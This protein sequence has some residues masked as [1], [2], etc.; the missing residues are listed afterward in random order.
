M[1]GLFP[2]LTAL[3]CINA[4]FVLMEFAL[5]RVRASRIEML[6]RKGNPRALQV[7]DVL[8]HLDVYLAAIQVGL[9]IVALT[10]GWIGEPALAERLGH[11]LG[12]LPVEAHPHLVHVLAYVLALLALAFFQTVF[13]ELLPRFVGIQKAELV[14]LWG[15]GALRLFALVF[16][17]PISFMSYCSST[18]LKLFG[19]K[20][21]GESESIVSEEEMRILLGE[22]Q[23]RGS[24]PLERLLLLENLFDLGAAKAAEAMV[25]LEKVAYLSLKRSWEEN[26]ET[27]RSRRFSRYPLC[28]DGPQ[29]PLGMIH[30]KDLV[31]RTEAGKVG[32]LRRLKRDIS[33]VA[34]SDPLEKLL[35]HFPDKGIH[36]AMVASAK[37][38]ITGLLTLEDIVEELIGEVHDEFDLPQAWSMMDI[39][40]PSAVAV[41][42]VATDRQ[43][44]IGHLLSRLKAVFP[45]LNEEETFKAVWSRETKFS[46]AVGRGVA[47]PHARFANLSRPMVAVGRFAKPVPFP[48]PDNIPVRL[49]FLILTPAASPIIQLKVLARIASLA[50]NENLRRKLLRAKTAEA[51]LEIL[52]TAD[53]LLAA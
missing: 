20:S 14:S 18:I 21:A 36:M 23:E 47:V 37:G 41:G 40:V 26:L 50:T 53:T 3:I 5:V 52:R 33:I 8:S 44:A 19:L 48:G 29:N 25:P 28:E 17:I 7:Q 12:K 38:E 4:L 10:L 13:G 11:W 1:A 35:K 46:S 31:L 30:V 39:V 24:L 9:T 16:R 6:A 2:I 15:V 34:E 42:I 32:D 51:M 49:V 27:I 43:S 22:T 45:E